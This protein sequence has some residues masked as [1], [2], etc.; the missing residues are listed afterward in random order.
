MTDLPFLEAA[1][2]PTAIERAPRTCPRHEWG[3]VDVSS[4][5]RIELPSPVGGFCIR[6]G[7]LRNLDASRR[8]RS[9]RKR[10]G[11]AE[12]DVAR[13]VGGNKVGPLG[14]PW[15]VELPGYMRLQVKKLATWPS[16]GQIAQWIDAIPASDAM[17]AVAVIQA[18]G[19]GKRGRRLLVLDLDEFARWHG[20]PTKGGRA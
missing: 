12:L 7:K 19:Q 20:D 9:N 4:G 17:R 18:A 14:H 8:G 5:T 10:G 16:L 1:P 3:Y 15:D 11:R 13:A 2:D 6:C